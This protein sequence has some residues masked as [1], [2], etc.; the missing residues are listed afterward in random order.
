MSENHAHGNSTQSDACRDTTKC[1]EHCPRTLT[2]DPIVDVVSGAEGKHVL[3]EDHGR[4]RFYGL[5]VMAVHDVGDGHGDT[6][7]DAKVDKGD[8]QDNGKLPR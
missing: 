7:N 6:Q 5:F 3:E 1:E 2:R 8:G 4:Y